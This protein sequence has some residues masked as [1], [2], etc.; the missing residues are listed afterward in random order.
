[1][2]VDGRAKLTATAAV[3]DEENNAYLPQL[4]FMLQHYNPNAKSLPTAQPCRLAATSEQLI[5]RK[6]PVA[7]IQLKK[8]FFR[9]ACCDSAGNFNFFTGNLAIM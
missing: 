3:I 9:S 6:Q 1:M 2:V 5:F 4:M 8:H 7:C